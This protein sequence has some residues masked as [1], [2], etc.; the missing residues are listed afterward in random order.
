M[1]RLALA[2]SD[3]WADVKKSPGFLQSWVLSYHAV[4]RR[5]L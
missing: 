1:R 2:I 3:G 5:A 4:S